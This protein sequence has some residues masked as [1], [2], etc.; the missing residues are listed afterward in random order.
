MTN[1]IQTLKTEISGEIK[2]AN[3]LKSLDDVRVTVLGKKGRITA[4]MKN[5]G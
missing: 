4:L 2:A 5:I 1:D 3:D